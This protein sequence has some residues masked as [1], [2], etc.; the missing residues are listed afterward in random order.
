MAEVT[1]SAV[2]EAIN[3]SF[4]QAVPVPT[5]ENG[6]GTSASYMPEYRVWCHMLQRCQNPN[7][8]SYKNYG[9]RGIEVCERWKKFSNFI[10]DMGSRPSPKHSIERLDNSEGYELDNCVWATGTIQGRNRRNNV[11]ISLDGRTQALS[12]WAEQLGVEGRLITSKLHHKWSIRDAVSN[13]AGVPRTDKHDHLTEFNLGLTATRSTGPKFRI[14]RSL[15]ELP[16]G[17]K[18]VRVSLKIPR[19]LKEHI[20]KMAAE[21]GITIKKLFNDVVAERLMRHHAN[22]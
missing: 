3:E 8:K 14:S 16:P 6:P 4:G 13:K 17:E 18:M 2:P 7:N 21:R 1:L 12:A 15:S 22:A 20:N 9:G 11:R 10:K 5:A 19:S